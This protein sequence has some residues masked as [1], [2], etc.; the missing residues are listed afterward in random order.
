MS[1]SLLVDVGNTNIKLALYQSTLH[2]S[3]LHQ[4]ASRVH[5]WHTSS[6]EQRSSHD[7]ASLINAWFEEAQIT[8]IQQVVMASVVAPVTKTLLPALNNIT[9]CEVALV[10]SQL[11]INLGLLHFDATNHHEV[12]PDLLVTAVA[13]LNTSYQTKHRLIIDMGSATTFN[14]VTLPN[15][16]AG[17]AITPGLDAMQDALLLKAPALPRV[18]LEAPNA[19]LGHDTTSALQAGLVLAYASLVDGM[20]DRVQADLKPTNLETTTS[21]DDASYYVIATGGTS[22]LIVPLCANI[23]VHKPQ[24]AFEGLLDVAR[25]LETD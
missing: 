18:P 17:V 4:G 2:Q 25:A 6:R 15:T 8:D 22:N 10:T 16:F 1:Y 12:G 24:L 21:G 9:G 20:I 3:T 13:A 19:P 11:M 23:D 5:S 7:Y 14:L